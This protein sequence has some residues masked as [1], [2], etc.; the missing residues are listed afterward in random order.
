MRLTMVMRLAQNSL[1]RHEIVNVEH[2]PRGG[3]RGGMKCIFF[4]HFTF[5]YVN[6]LGNHLLKLLK[7][8]KLSQWEF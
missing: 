1:C 8:R 2:W 4:F 5:P 7:N 3:G 6:G